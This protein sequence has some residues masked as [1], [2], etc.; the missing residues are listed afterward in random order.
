MFSAY[1][2]ALILV[3]FLLTKK[4]LSICL[5]LGSIFILSITMSSAMGFKKKRVSIL[6]LKE[7]ICRRSNFKVKTKSHWFNNNDFARIRV[8]DDI[9][10]DNKQ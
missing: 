2:R 5:I 6:N 9:N 8:Y 3:Y 4:R 1:R 7:L 10:D